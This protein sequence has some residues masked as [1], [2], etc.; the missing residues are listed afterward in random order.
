MII[1]S[2][3]QFF[4]LEEPNKRRQDVEKIREVIPGLTFAEAEGTLRIH[5]GVVEHAIEALISEIEGDQSLAAG[6]QESEKVAEK[7]VG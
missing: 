1:E 2:F 6:R 3:F 4:I 7:V 5:R